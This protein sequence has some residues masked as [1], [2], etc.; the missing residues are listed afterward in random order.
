LD[1]TVPPGKR[2]AARE[3]VAGILAPVL[4]EHPQFAHL[5]VLVS[6]DA[7]RGGWQVDVVVLDPALSP[8][9]TD[10]PLDD[11]VLQGMR[12]ALARL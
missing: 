10:M 6:R 5:A 7:R 3:T 12:E 11:G 9:G 4:R 8:T 2:D 1:G